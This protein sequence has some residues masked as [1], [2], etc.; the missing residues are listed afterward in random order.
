MHPATEA[1]WAF[2]NA[3]PSHRFMAQWFLAP[4][5]Y[6][7]DRTITVLAKK[8]ATHELTNQYA[9]GD[10]VSWPVAA[11]LPG[12]AMVLVLNLEQKQLVFVLH[13]RDD[14]VE[15]WAFSPFGTPALLGAFVPGSTRMFRHSGP[16][17]PVDR[18]SSDNFM[19]LI[20]IIVSLINEQRRV[21][22]QPVKP[23]RQTRKRQEHLTGQPA[24]AWFRVSW[25]IGK[26][27][28]AKGGK[29]NSN[30]TTVALH[31][32]RAHWRICEKSAP[33]AT[34]H[35][36]RR[37]WY[38]W[39]KDCWKGHPDNGVRLHHYEPRLLD[40]SRQSRRK[41]APHR[42]SLAVLNAAKAEALRLAGFAT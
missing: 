1:V 38:T 29:G 12:A 34:W 16:F 5:Q 23:E 7:I 15:V 21:E 37:A 10:F 36:P 24:A 9:Q 32:C 14:A 22:A 35:A 28:R 6:E 42:K 30:A 25:T 19:F 39:V 27:V 20:A 2:V 26:T 8:I 3:K 17:R 11:Q 41:V 33:G 4:A 18:Q 31:W 13:R 40:A